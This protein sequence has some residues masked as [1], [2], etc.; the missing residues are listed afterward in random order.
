MINLRRFRVQTRVCWIYA[1]RLRARKVLSYPRP[2]SST[3]NMRSADQPLSPHYPLHFQSHLL[4]IRAPHGS[5][6]THVPNVRTCLQSTN[7]PVTTVVWGPSF[8]RAQSDSLKRNKFRSEIPRRK[9]FFKGKSDC[10][11]EVQWRRI[12]IKVTHYPENWIPFSRRYSLLRDT[13]CC[14]QTRIEVHNSVKNLVERFVHF[15]CKSNM[16]K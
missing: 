14:G 7:Y 12:L 1:M 15:V 11:D 8:S 13:L 3:R 16:H 10:S 5:S 2:S 9:Q 6:V 4:L